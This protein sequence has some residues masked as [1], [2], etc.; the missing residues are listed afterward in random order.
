[1]TK[2]KVLVVGADSLIGGFLIKFLQS[3]NIYDCF[4]TTRKKYSKFKYLDLSYPLDFDFSGYSTVIMCASITNIRKCEDDKCHCFDINVTKTKSIIDKAVL[5]GCF[6]VFLSSNSVF[7]GKKAFCG[8][9]D[10]IFPV[11]FYG[12]TKV[13]V[14]K[15]AMENYPNMCC[16]LR[17]TKV[18]VSGNIPF[19]QR[20]EREAEDFGFFRVFQDHFLSP[21]TVEEA[22]E[23]ILE[24]ILCKKGGI[25]QR[26]GADEIS[27]L[28]FAKK[29]YQNNSD[30]LRKIKIAE[31]DEAC[32]KHNSLKTYL[33][34][35]PI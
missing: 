23:A 9:R 18:L 35:K 33:P 4:G 16:I 25:F 10:P 19:L 27:Y 34:S 12:F 2:E 1:M 32:I 8:V 3:K 26:G 31:E 24:C 17:M 22:A 6:V 13:M 30:M 28:D 20:W 29:C 14:E 21:I 15:Y 7:N 5:S 11:S